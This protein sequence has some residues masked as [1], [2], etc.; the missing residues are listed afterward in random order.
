MYLYYIITIGCSMNQSDSERIVG[1]LEKHKYA[2]ANSV[3]KADFVIINTCGVRQS[4]ENRAYGLVDRIKKQNPKTKI[5]LTGC[6]SQ[7]KDVIKKLKDKVD[8]W[9]KITELPKLNLKL[10]NL[11]AQTKT[12][13]N[14]EV[15]IRSYSAWN[16]AHHPVINNISCIKNLSNKNQNNVEVGGIEPPEPWV[17]SRAPHLVTPTSDSLCHAP[18]NYLNIKPKYQSKFS[19]FVPIGNGCN[20]FCSYCVVP[21]ARG[22]EAYRPVKDILKEVEELVKNNYKEIILIAQNV[23]SYQSQIATNLESRIITNLKTN[24]YKLN[25][26]GL[27]KLINNIPGNF[28]IRFLTSHPKDMSDELIQTI[29][30]CEKVC[31]HIHLPAQSGD[32]EI[33]KAMNR[34]YTVEHYKKLINK[35]CKAINSTKTKTPANAEDFVYSNLMRKVDCQPIISN[36]AYIKKLSSKNQKD[37]EVGGIEPSEHWLAIQRPHQVTPTSNE[38]YHKNLNTRNLWNLP[39]SITTDVIVGFPGETKKQFNNTVKLFKE[40]KFDMAYISQ[41]SL[42]PGAA[43]EKLKDNVTKQEKKRRE[44]ELTKILRKTALENNKK[45]LGQVV[46][47]LVD[48]KN[49][50]E[51]WHGKT[52]TGKQLSIVNDQLSIKNLAGKFVKVKI[53]D[54]KDF[55]LKGEISL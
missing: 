14:T 44:Q 32:N 10:K 51:E 4:A 21:Y 27:L 50:R 39:A 38:L 11:F 15:F 46:D 30:E 18:E 35:I 34:N 1:Y 8:V 17:I 16:L 3:E 41:Y 13:V 42:R 48:D 53:I 25:F 28:W 19:A 7:R 26:S 20:N 23:N 12:P 6:L 22:R 24:N 49:K 37:V 47:V 45:Y 55:G 31:E 36:I 29:A 40:V 2:M 5:I 43:A 33:L 54:V 9:L 52:K